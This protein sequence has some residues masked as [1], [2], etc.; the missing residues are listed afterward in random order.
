MNGFLQ[1]ICGFFNRSIPDAEFDN[2]IDKFARRLGKFPKKVFD[3]SK[4]MVNF[5]AKAIFICRIL[6]TA[7]LN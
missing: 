1:L 3:L 5:L 7:I 2:F 4:E 6:A